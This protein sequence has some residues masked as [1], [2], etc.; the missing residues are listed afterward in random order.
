M[1]AVSCHSVSTLLS[2]DDI[3]LLSKSS[4]GL[5]QLCDS[6]SEWCQWSGLTLNVSKCH[7]FSLSF[8]PSFQAKGP[9]ITISGQPIKCVDNE[10]FSFLGLPIN[11]HLNIN[12]VKNDLKSK[13]HSLLVKIDSRP[14][15]RHRKLQLYSQGLFPRISWHL[16][17]VTLSQTWLETELDRMVTSFLKKWTHLHRSACT[18]RL[19]LEKSQGDLG[20]PCPSSRSLVL[21]SSKSARFLTSQDSCIRYMATKAASD[22]SHPERFSSFRAGLKALCNDPSS[23]SVVISDQTKKQLNSEF[24]H[25]LLEKI[26]SRKVQGF[27]SRLTDTSPDIWSAVMYKLPSEQFSFALNAVSETLPTNANLLLWRKR[28]CDKCPLCSQRQTLL[29]VLNNCTVLL[30]KG[31]YYSSS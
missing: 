21:Q 23:S 7:S 4:Q 15:S 24:Q 26:Q 3:S 11:S 12:K 5:Q 2:A 22:Q 13:I 30:N 8:K 20:L 6:V 25:Q 14:V 10:S 17:L 16:C 9:S 31:L 28:D 29:H 1:E 27:T 19:F 18:A